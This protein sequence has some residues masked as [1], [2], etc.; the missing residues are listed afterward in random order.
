MGNGSGPG[1]LNSRIYTNS[2]SSQVSAMAYPFRN[3]G[4]SFGGLSR[5]Q[6]SYVTYHELADN[7][8]GFGSRGARWSRVNKIKTSFIPPF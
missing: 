2:F 7:S 8:S 1:G 3:Q 5:P 6:Y 4:N